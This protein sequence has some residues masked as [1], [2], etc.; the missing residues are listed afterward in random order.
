MN[1]LLV[2]EQPLLLEGLER[3]LEGAAGFQVI[4]S[5]RRGL[6][7]LAFARD[8]TPDL[9]VLAT[10]LGDL[11]GAEVCRRMIAVAPLCEIVILSAGDDL[12]AVH[13]CLDNGAAG[14]V[15]RSTTAEDLIAA[16]QLVAAGEPAVE[17]CLREGLR[18]FDRRQADGPAS[19]PLRPRELEVLRMM[20]TGAGT[21]AIAD[22][23]GLSV[24]TVRTYIQATL[25]KM[26]AHSRIQAV[27]IAD[28]RGLI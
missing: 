11:D 5:C 23:L 21:K 4:G 19:A 13:C 8:V 14:V 22:E 10:R 24:N 17:P 2:D 20:A 18:G 15:L 16:L 3:V 28:R 6:E 9:V 26:G 1:V 7:A 25:E 27:V 12:Y